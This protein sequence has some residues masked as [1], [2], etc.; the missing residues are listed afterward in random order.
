M[1]ANTV[2]LTS[3]GTS[4]GYPFSI[5]PARG[6]WAN[7]TYVSS[8]LCFGSTTLSWTQWDVYDYALFAARE[9]GL[10]VIL[11]LTDNYDYY[12][13][14]KYTF[15]R[16]RNVTDAYRG[17][18]FYSQPDVVSDFLVR[19]LS[20]SSSHRVLI[21]REQAY[22]HRLLTRNNSYTGLPYGRDPTILAWETANELGTSGH[23]CC[24]SAVL[25]FDVRWLRRSRWNVPSHHLDSDCLRLHQRFCLAARH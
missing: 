22:T 5:E 15:L 14:G 17:A 19:H 20:L 10:R 11:P 4:V 23:D 9:Y 24:F 6:V 12:H 1:G 13:G 16:W 25:K 21:S 2:R 3:C 8:F 18:L 7:E